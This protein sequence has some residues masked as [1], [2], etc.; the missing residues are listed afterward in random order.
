MIYFAR[1]SSLT[2]GTMALVGFFVIGIKLLYEPLL[3]EMAQGR[4]LA[5]FLF[6]AAG[7]CLLFVGQICGNDLFSLR[8][9][10]NIFSE[11]IKQPRSVGFYGGEGYLSSLPGEDTDPYR[12]SAP[13]A[14]ATTTPIATTKLEDP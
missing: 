9:R 8:G 13:E 5:L 11:M 14:S 12:Q 7:C 2:G 3:P 6:V 10:N 4:W 1:L